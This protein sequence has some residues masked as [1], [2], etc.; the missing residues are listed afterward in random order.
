[1]TESERNL[2]RALLTRAATLEVQRQAA[3]ERGDHPAVREHE[4]ELSRLWARYVDLD[5]RG[6]CVA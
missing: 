5:Q 6:E 3:V 2:L 1:M 4:I